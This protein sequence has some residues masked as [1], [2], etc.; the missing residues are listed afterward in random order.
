MHR[1]HL[2]TMVLFCTSR[3]VSQHPHCDHGN[4]TAL[5]IIQPTP[6][7]SHADCLVRDLSAT[8]PFN[9]VI[10][11]YVVHFQCTITLHISYVHSTFPHTFPMY[12]V[13]FQ[14]TLYIS[15]V[16]YSVHFLCTL[17]IS[18]VHFLCTLYISSVHYLAHFLCTLYI[19]SVLLTC[20]FPMYLV[21]FLCTIHFTHYL[22]SG[23]VNALGKPVS[24]G[25]ASN[26]L[27]G[28]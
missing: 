10:Q 24:I 18:S 16:H 26:C 25:S 20:T 11:D 6:A 14:C 22:P 8:N 19:S 3:E 17:Y 13:H 15:S 28:G 4:W 23:A 1:T 21:H 12:I 9:S 2:M 5:K 7:E 27:T